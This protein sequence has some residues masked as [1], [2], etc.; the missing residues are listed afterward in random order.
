[1]TS[2]ALAVSRSRSVR[3]VPPTGLAGAVA[4]YRVA[5]GWP[6]AG[7]FCLW[8]AFAAGVVLSL[9]RRDAHALGQPVVVLFLASSALGFRLYARR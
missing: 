9:A 5:L 3:D 8:A 4:P 7:L 1:M 6:G 2:A